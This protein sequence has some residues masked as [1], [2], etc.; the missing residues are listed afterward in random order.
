MAN[1]KQIS[2][3]GKLLKEARE[4]QGH[5]LDDV[6]KILCISKRHLIAMEEKHEDHL[7]DVYTIGFLRSYAQ[8]LGLD[9]NEISQRFKSQATLV[10]P[11]F[12]PFPAPVPGKGMPS[13]RILILSIFILLIFVGV[14]KW[15]DYSQ[16]APSPLEEIELTEVSKAPPEVVENDSPIALSTSN[17]EDESIVPLSIPIAL[18]EDS[19]TISPPS[20]IAKL[21]ESPVKDDQPITPSLENAELIE[22]PIENAPPIFP[23]SSVVLKASQES[24]VEVKDRNGTVIVSRIFTPNETYEF[25][26]PKNL[27]LKTGNANGIQLF[28]GEQTFPFP[29]KSGGVQ[30]DIS[31]DPEK[32]VEQRP[33]TL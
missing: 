1:E 19:S 18:S 20:E 25:K 5:S 3:V 31:L 2:S 27:I 29:K 33:D 15:K 28:S 32:W 22:P 16:P 26:E 10:E 17:S 7:C 21:I 9:T 13:R 14:W 6:S 12:L 8:F 24:W 30:S 23:T 11:A 4:L